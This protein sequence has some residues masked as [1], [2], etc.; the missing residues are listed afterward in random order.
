MQSLNKCRRNFRGTAFRGFTLIELLLVLV[1]ISILAAVV[2]TK[3]TGRT[4]QARIAAATQEIS[5][6]KTALQAFETDNDT[7][8]TS[9]DALVNNP[10]NLPNW[11]HAYLEKMPVDPWGRP[12]VYH[13]PP[14]SG[15]NNKDFDLYSTGPSGQ[16]Q[17]GQGDNISD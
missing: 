4:R 13:F 10:G 6:I 16:D 7:F 9:L 1:I 17:G 15:A 2:A 12:Y 8:P 14:S 11:K 5:N 3:F